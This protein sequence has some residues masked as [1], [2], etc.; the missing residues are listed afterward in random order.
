MKT[1]QDN[2]MTNFTCA[3]YSENDINYYDRS[4]QVQTVKK[5]RQDNNMTDHT[6]V[7]Y[8]KNETKLSWTIK[9]GVVYHE[10]QTG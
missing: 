10:N 5:T 2:D 7:V 4:N 1:R 8:T 3:T 6:S 9:P